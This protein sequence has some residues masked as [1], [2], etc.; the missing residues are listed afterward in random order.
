[1]VGTVEQEVLNP[2]STHFKAEE[3]Q[4]L[5]VNDLIVYVRANS[6]GNKCAFEAGHEIMS[7]SWPGSFAALCSLYLFVFFGF[8]S[9]N[10]LRSAK[11]QIG[12]YTAALRCLLVQSLPQLLYIYTH[13][14]IYIHIQYIYCISPLRQP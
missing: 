7:L 13:I 8:A 12:F 3:A 10:C 14:Y 5:V 2:W 9:S 6:R 4:Y 11:L 1:M